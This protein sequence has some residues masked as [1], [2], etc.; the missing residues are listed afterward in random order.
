MPTRQQESS[1]ESGHRREPRGQRF[2]DVDAA[3]RD[4]SV[5]PVAFPR[6]ANW[7]RLRMCLM[8]HLNQPRRVD[9][10][11]NRRTLHRIPTRYAGH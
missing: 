4:H 1:Q 6:P 8:T 7:A 11:T 9:S 5:R 3:A 10:S 2:D